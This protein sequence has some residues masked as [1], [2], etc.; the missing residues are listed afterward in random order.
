MLLY[1]FFSNVLYLYI[2]IIQLLQ[3]VTLLM[4]QR[5]DS[6]VQNT[7]CVLKHGQ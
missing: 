3:L 5:V 6:Y 4:Y 7:V 2:Q 1:I